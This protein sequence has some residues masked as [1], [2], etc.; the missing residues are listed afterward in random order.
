MSKFT[1]RGV[2]LP[3]LKEPA[4]SRPILDMSVPSVLLVPLL[5]GDGGECRL[6]GSIPLT[7]HRGDPLGLPRTEGGC[8]V[9]APAGGTVTALRELLHPLLGLVECAVLETSP[10]QS[11]E[12]PDEA[13]AADSVS[14]D[15]IIRTARCAGIINELSGAMLSLE[16]EEWRRRGGLWLVADASEQEPY[17]S[18][19]WLLLRE[20]GGGIAK[21]LALAAR[22]IGAAGRHVAVRGERA[23][24][25]PRFLGEDTPFFRVNGKYPAAVADEAVGE[26][27]RI[28]VQACLALWQAAACNAPPLDCVVTVTGDAVA[29]P[30][31][32]RVPAGTKLADLLHTCG[33]SENPGYVLIGDALTG[34]TV[35]SDEIPVVPGM[36]CVLAQKAQER[37]PCHNCIGCGRC[38]RAC[39]ADLLP[40]EIM[41]R[42]D[43]MQYERL[44]KLLT[45]ACDGCGACSYVCPAGLD[46]TAKVLEARDA[47]GN[48][49][50]NW[51]DDDDL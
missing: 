30:Q 35:D 17:A 7:V 43:N 49:F 22:V 10:E 9:F 11:P 37:P 40:Y 19:A 25:L 38:V 28:G 14:A 13:R 2:W 29:N 6:A 32:V 31:N 51:G 20:H 39:H 23:A 4:A 27:A 15:A 50:L 34:L 3:S 41:R 16:L 5:A 36:T 24:G 47:H 21:G 33:L 18:S 46:V 45:S 8:P 1:K 26:P 48:I 12:E 42:L 44:E